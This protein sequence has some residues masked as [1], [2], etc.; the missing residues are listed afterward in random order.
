MGWCAMAWPANEIIE[1]KIGYVANSQQCYNVLHYVPN[2]SGVGNLPVELSQAIVDAL[3][4]QAATAG[5]L[6]NSMRNMMSEDV[7]I[8]ELTAQ[9]IWPT[10]YRMFKG[11]YAFAGLLAADPCP[12][13][14]IAA[15]V[16]KFGAG[17]NRKDVGSMHLGGLALSLYENG[18]LTVGG[19]A[20]L[21]NVANDM[22]DDIVTTTFGNVTYSPVILNKVP[23]IIDGKTKYQISGFTEMVGTIPKTEVRVMRRRTVRVG[24]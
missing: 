12:V 8:N 2:D 13:Q 3:D 22:M 15:V 9:G 18:E 20:A 6:L 17:G 24:I 23:V 19:Q 5:T 11:S 1:V 7:T 10:R 14:N 21:L 16:Q 4:S